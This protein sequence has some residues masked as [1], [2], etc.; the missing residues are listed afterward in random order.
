MLNR[1]TPALLEIKRTS[2]SDT[3]LFTGYVTTW[4][5][6]PDSY[7]DVIKRGAFSDALSLHRKNDTMPAMLWSHDMSAPI[8]KWLDFSEDNHGLLGTGQLTL[9]T[10]RGS[11]AYALL[12]D[13]AIGLSVG[14]TLA[15]D[16]A[17]TQGDVREI[18]KVARLHEISLVSVPA[19]SNARVTN[20]KRLEN[21]RKFERVLRDVGFS[22]REAKRAIAG[23][24]V[25]IARDER[26][27]LDVVLCKIE[28]F[29]LTVTRK[30]K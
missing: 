24:L 16:G 18:T 21:P 9:G 6:Q 3:G 1:L 11:E 5:G 26:S 4:G 25:G 7:G 20:V 12:K 17:T 2:V 8:G 13:D 30:I 10:Q 14:F 22:A 15:K 27:N 19:N 29:K 28:D 23:G